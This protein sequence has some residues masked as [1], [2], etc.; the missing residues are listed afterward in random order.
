MWF[1]TT[2]SILAPEIPYLT[3]DLVFTLFIYLVSLCINYFFIFLAFFPFFYWHLILIKKFQTSFFFSFPF[4]FF[5]VISCHFI[6]NWPFAVTFQR[7]YLIFF[8]WW[9]VVLHCF[10]PKQMLQLM[11]I[12]WCIIVKLSFFTY[13]CVLMKSR[14]ISRDILKKLFFCC[15]CKTTEKLWFGLIF[16]RMQPSPIPKSFKYG[17]YFKGTSIFKNIL[18]VPLLRNIQGI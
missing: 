9:R 18:N 3:F 6:Q 5:F 4:F 13:E 12:W 10:D 14:R 17:L 1:F 7:V 15:S 8:T 16:F 2:H 11:C